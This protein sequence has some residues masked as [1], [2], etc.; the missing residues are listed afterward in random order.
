MSVSDTFVVEAG[1]GGTTAAVFNVALSVPSGRAVRAG[2][3]VVRGAGDT[4]TAGVDFDVTP[5]VVTFEPGETSAT[6]AVPVFGDS[7]YEGTETFSVLL[8]FTDVPTFVMGDGEAVATV[9]EDDALPTLA[10]GA[11]TAAEGDDPAGRFVDVPLTLSAPAGVE[12]A[13]SYTTADDSAAAPGDYEAVAGTVSFQPGE[14]AKAIRVRVIGDDVEEPQEAF[15]IRFTD[16]RNAAAPGDTRVAV[17][18]DDA[19][20]PVVTGVFVSGT[21]WAQAFLTHLAAIEAGSARFGFLLG[22]GAAQLDELPWTNLNR[23]TLRFNRDVTAHEAN[24]V[25]RGAGGGE[26]AS[27]VEYDRDLHAYT[28]TFVRP[29]PAERLAVRL[30]ATSQDGVRDALTGLRLDGEWASGA[31]IYP[32]G[33]GSPGG[34]FTCGI[35][36]VPGDATRDGKVDGSDLLAVRARQRTGVGRVGFRSNGYSIFSDLNGSGSVDAVDNALVRSRQG[37]TLPPP[38]AASSA[39]P[40]R[41]VDRMVPPRRRLFSV[42]PVLA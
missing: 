15:W 35:H 42:A 11:V 8:V 31:D 41:T 25:V 13:L 30:D 23:I 20:L 38:P 36:I 24:A 16:V 3:Q 39:G 9:G 29:F 5:G 2:Y 14:I 34:D 18:D 7:L 12:V 19:E 21:A 40:T 27:T 22:G 17:A 10:V 26:Y 4:A 33:D 6:I 28:W 32:S 37:T 1:D